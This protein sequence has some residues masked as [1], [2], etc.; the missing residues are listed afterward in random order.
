MLKQ[1][2]FGSSRTDKSSAHPLAGKL[3]KTKLNLQLL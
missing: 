2:Q 1:C 3:H